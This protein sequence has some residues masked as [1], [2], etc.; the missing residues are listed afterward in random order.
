MRLK[1]KDLIKEEIEP[2]RSSD[3]YNFFFLW[4]NFTHHSEIFDT[5]YGKE[6]LNYYLSKLKQKYVKLFTDL[7]NKQIQK[8]IQKGRVDKDFPINDFNLNIP[9]TQSLNLINK[10]W[11]SDMTRRNTKWILL[12]E[13]VVKL[14]NAVTPKDIFLYINQIYNITHNTNFTIFDKFSNYYKELKKAFDF[15]DSIQNINT[16]LPYIDQDLKQLANQ[17]INNLSH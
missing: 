16:L 15:V 14:N 1:L 5:P 4:Y 11:R 2:I 12:A 6:T 13:F 8:Y 9:I 17:E 10:T 7:I 3:I